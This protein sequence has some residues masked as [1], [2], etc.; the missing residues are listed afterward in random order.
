MTV[1]T[2]KRLT[3]TEY[4]IYDDGSDT[5]YELVDGVLVEMGA[6]SRVNIQIAIF[7]L[8]C[9]TKLGLTANQLGIKEKIQV[10]SSHASA[11]DPDLI[12]HS[13]ESTLAIEG[14]KESCLFLGEPNP[15]LVVEI[16]SPGNE[17]SENYQRDYVQKPKEYAERGIAEY[18]IVDPDRA[19]V[20]VGVLVEGAYQFATFQDEQAIVSSAFPV[21]NWTAAAV[22]RAGR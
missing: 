18:W 1:A 10:I 13:E 9:F 2:D 3:L 11:R 20:M 14:R 8:Q 16:V 15:L 4:L 22:L 19:W 6:E 7:L 21:L 12:I 17:S 5:R